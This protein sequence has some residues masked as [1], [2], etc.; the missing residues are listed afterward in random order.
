MS[1]T[2]NCN[3]VKTQNILEKYLCHLVWARQQIAVKYLFSCSE[4]G[5]RR[6]TGTKGSLACLDGLRGL[7]GPCGGNLPPEELA[8]ELLKPEPNTL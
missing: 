8:P 6:L 2:T 5:K 3:E 7:L 4:T 1:D